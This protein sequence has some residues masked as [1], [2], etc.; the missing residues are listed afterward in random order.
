MVG[1][2][3]G[4]H[5]VEPVVLDVESLEGEVLDHELLRDQD[6]LPKNLHQSLNTNAAVLA[7]MILPV[8]D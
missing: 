5:G 1:K 3:V 8:G 7:A 4:D 6:E 2:C